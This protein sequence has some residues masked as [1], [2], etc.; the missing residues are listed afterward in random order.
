[1]KL[2]IECI[3]AGKYIFSI[4]ITYKLIGSEEDKIKRIEDAIGVI[5]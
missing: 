5:E 2:Y 3:W 4:I 1:M